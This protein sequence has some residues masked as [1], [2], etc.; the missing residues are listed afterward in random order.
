MKEYSP[1]EKFQLEWIQKYGVDPD[2]Y[3]DPELEED[4]A[5]LKKY[6]V[7]EKR[8]KSNIEVDEEIDLHGEDIESGLFILEQLL[9]RA[10]KY[11]YKRV[12][13]IHGVGEIGIS[14]KSLRLEIRRFLNSSAKGW[15]KDWQYDN[16]TEGSLIINL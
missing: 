3:G 10:V 13:V 5:S 4:M 9:K 7:K 6:H 12:R 16:P 2:K 8:I 1:E 14:A 15:Y 11:G